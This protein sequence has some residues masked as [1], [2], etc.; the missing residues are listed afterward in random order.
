METLGHRITVRPDPVEKVSS[1]GIVIPD[2]VADGR[3]YIKTT[4]TI[5]DVGPDAWKSF[6]QVGEDGKLVNGKPWA[7]VGDRVLYSKNSGRWIQ[8]PNGGPDLI[9]MLDEDVL[10]KLSEIENEND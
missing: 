7:A 6:R 2:A 8:D 9:V 1:G 4:G 3:K 10:L 5:V